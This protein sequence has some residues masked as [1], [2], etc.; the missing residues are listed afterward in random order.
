MP[1]KEF[2]K[3]KKEGIVYSVFKDGLNLL[4]DRRI[5]VVSKKMEYLS[6]LGVVTFPEC[7]FW[8]LGLK[9]TLDKTGIKSAEGFLNFSK[10]YIWQPELLVPF[11]SYFN[12][13]EN[14]KK[15]FYWLS[16]FDYKVPRGFSLKEVW[17]LAKSTEELFLSLL[18]KGEGSTPFGDDL[19]GG[20]IYGKLIREKFEGKDISLAQEYFLSILYQNEGKTT[21]FGEE[22]LRSFILLQPPLVV[23]LLVKKLFELQLDE[24]S[25]LRSLLRVIRLGHSSGWGIAFGVLCGLSNFRERRPLVY[26]IS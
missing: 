2:I 8:A 6:A 5:V 4:V 23:K 13:I 7:P 12:V 17:R 25:L 3:Q 21:L 1:L 15:A 24:K 14:L 10:A 22:L 20:F 9:V 18:G 26:G 16:L 19:L 11:Y